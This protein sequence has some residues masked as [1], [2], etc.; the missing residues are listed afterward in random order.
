MASSSQLVKRSD[1]RTQAIVL[2][3]TKYQESDRILN[4]L[5]PEGKRSVIARGVRKEK[6]K[7]AGGVEMF[8]ISEVT[9]HYRH[10]QAE[11][12]ETLGILTSAKMRHFYAGILGNLERL[13]LA[14]E[15]IRA[16]NRLSEQV[17]SPELFDITKQVFEALG[18]TNEQQP[19]D[20]NTDK[21]N[22]DRS[23]KDM[24][25][26]PLRLVK[27]WFNVNFLRLSGEELNLHFDTSGQP[28]RPDQTYAW[29]SLER[30]LVPQNRGGITAKH[31]KLLR[32]M[33]T[34]PLALV[35]KVRGVE[36]LMDGVNGIE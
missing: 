15:I 4:L 8:C 28:L 31:I 33:S 1:V 12:S 29:D 5:T 13:E 32:L 17:D 9:I 20:M 18:E 21:M 6:S 34:A 7:L 3:R 19:N 24:V 14:S 22:M 35:A 23:Q 2:S 11:Q 36:E 27:T 25:A 30:A 10:N 26:M 16:V